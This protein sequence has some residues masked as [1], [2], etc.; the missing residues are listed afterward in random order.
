MER[1]M[2]RKAW[3]L[4]LLTIILQGEAT[5]A[6][7]I[8]GLFPFASRSHKNVYG[9]I[10][11]ALV[12]KGHHFTVVTSQPLQ[13]PPPNY[14]QIDVSEIVSHEFSIFNT[15]RKVRL[16]DMFVEIHGLIDKIC[17]VMMQ[18][19]QVKA[20]VKPG[21][22]VKYDLILMSSF[23]S[24]CLY[25]FAR[26]YNAPI[27]LV[28]PSGPLA[29]TYSA[30][31]NVMLPSYFADPITGYSD[32]M[33]FKERVINTFVN[34]VSLIFNKL[35]VESLMEYNMR[36]EF[37]EDT[38]S[39]SELEEYVSLAVLNNHLS[40]NQA[41]P[42]VPCLIEA[43]GLHIKPPKELPEDLKAFLD[44][45]SKDG[46][47]YFSLGSIL[48]SSR[49]PK[50]TRDQ[51]I[52]AFSRVKQRVLWK[53]EGENPI[54]GQSINV[55]LEKWVP[56]Q[57]VLAHPNVKMF[58][59][60]GG[61]LSFQEA[62][63]RGVPI[64]GIP[65]FGDQEMNMM[66][67]RHL[68][69]GVQLDAEN[70][71]ASNILHAVNEILDDPTYSENMKRLQAIVTDQKDDPLERAIYWIEYVIRHKGAK[72]LKPA[73]F[74][75]Q[76]YQICMLDVLLVLVVIPS[77]IS[78][79]I[80]FACFKATKKLCNSRRKMTNPKKKNRY[81][82]DGEQRGG[83]KQGMLTLGV[84]PRTIQMGR[85]ICMSICALV[86]V[87]ILLQ[88]DTTQAA[89][90]LALF[91]LA[92]R[93][94]NNVY[95][96][97]T[98]ALAQKGH[99]FTVVTSQPIDSPPTNYRQIDVHKLVAH[100]LAFNLTNEL[101]PLELLKNL[102]GFVEDICRVMM[103]KE[104]N[105]LVKPGGEKKFDLI[106]LSNF[107]NECY[108]AFAHVYKIPM[109]LIS[110]GGPM[111]STYSAVGNVMLPS[112]YSESLM[113]Y[114][115]RM[116]FKERVMNTL[117]VVGFSLFYKYYVQATMEKEMRAVFGEDTP[118]ISELEEH[119]SLAVLNS[120]FSLSQARPTVPCLIEAG[121]LHIKPP[122]DLPKDLK[123]FLDG[124][125]K[126]GVIYFSLGSVLKSSEF[127]KQ[128]VDAFISAFSQVKQRVLWKWE[129]ERPI[130][131]QPKNVRPE[132]WLPQQDVLAHP[133]V[134]LFITHGGLLSFQEAASRG[135]PVIGIPYYGDQESNM[136]NVV[137]LHVGVR[138]DPKNLTSINIL[139]AIKHVLE[140]V[141]YSDNMKRIQS[142]V[143][144]Q[145]DD[146]LERAVYWIEY[147]IR[148]NG[149]KHLKPAAFYLQWYQICMLD[150][151]LVL[152]VIPS[153]V[154][155]I[156]ALIATKMFKKMCASKGKKTIST[157]K[158]Q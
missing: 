40:I 22:G 119:V 132:K 58:I 150:V 39:I 136:K 51:L 69:V 90:I 65:H 98:R 1:K 149:A 126:D 101:G 52:D 158:T 107:F 33:N 145:R 42:L 64:I 79:G 146:P 6:A 75:L 41:R 28:S 110:P 7:N 48:R 73:A 74:Y 154:T 44:G 96:T 142:I 31:G 122:K 81:R 18:K 76:W 133:S 127:P 38:P 86:L 155:S 59:S 43:G 57:D 70:L 2:W 60:H 89:N 23:F 3:I 94:H 104:V 123:S 128:T 36:R 130:P 105:E 19:E 111:P 87:S 46:V 61:L 118:S 103:D 140:N 82:E 113:A 92:S 15:T 80:A 125:G 45:A 55:R 144:D 20:L 100:R 131:G 68:G 26:I 35:Y 77:L 147:V 120:H 71:T 134:K 50:E 63:S 108:Y 30:V 27:V 157:K 135:V 11:N 24:E 10:T 109:V 4:S 17:R 32:R 9:S 62:A 143:T 124:A 137:D 117:A 116:N 49:L 99:H 13:S 138:L 153:I 54:P 95:S 85:K 121:G 151:L 97:I 93:S 78:L 16:Y 129:G 25:P 5:S 112:Y 37:G 141:T 34:L 12:Q 139:N 53:W 47:I 91:P 114:S 84:D 115:D 21:V 8:L 102:K 72:H 106:I 67:I 88:A 148:H 56:Q 66:R 156:V 29:P 83:G 14:H 152:V